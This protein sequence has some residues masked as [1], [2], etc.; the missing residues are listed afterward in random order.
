M[1]KKLLLLLCTTFTLQLSY[2]DVEQVKAKL[3]S[4][5]PQLAIEN[6]QA[7]ES[8]S[9]YSA[10]LNNQIIYVD[11]DVQHLFYGSMFRIQDQ[12][13]L[14]QDLM[15]Q[16]NAVDF[17]KL[18]LQDAIKTVRGNGKHQLA[19][20]S[21][22]N[23]PYCKTLESHLAK[24]IDVTIYTFIYPIKAQ[25]VEPSKKVWCSANKEL[26][27]KALIQKA[28]QPKAGSNCDH[29][30][31][32][33]LKLGQQLKLQGTPVIIFENGFKLTGAY[34]AADIE[35]IWKQLKL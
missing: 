26:A 31:D 32:R 35:N 27:W 21:D 14:T 34:P 8:K 1:I 10:T 6:V 7:T 33:N 25:S 23:C 22:P 29:P 18:P 13:N 2:A 17:K 28:E 20:F 9:L 5:Y 24:L 19:I 3:K 16:H 4:Q 12:K 15:L 11:E 30:I